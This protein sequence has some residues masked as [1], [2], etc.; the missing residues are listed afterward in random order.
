MLLTILLLSIILRLTD[1]RSSPEHSLEGSL[2][3]LVEK[4]EFRLREMELRLEATERSMKK[5]NEKQAKEKKEQ[6]ARNKEM[7]MRLEAKDKEMETRLEELENKMIEE[8]KEKEM[9]ASTYKLRTD[10]E[11]SLINEIASN[12]S[13]NKVLPKPS[14][15]DLPIVLICAWQPNSITSSQT[16]NI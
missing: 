6:E 10:V 1:A 14:P 15:L 12:F 4:L 2:E 3:N 16:V 13:S 9:G 5:E 7:K 8:K 11:G